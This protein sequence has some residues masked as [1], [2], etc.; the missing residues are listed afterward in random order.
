[1]SAA[2]PAD[3]R[4]ASAQRRRFGCFPHRHKESQ[5]LQ[6]GPETC[7]TARLAIYRNGE[8]RPEVEEVQGTGPGELI[9]RLS[10][11]VTAVIR[12]E[13]GAIPE[14]AVDALISNLMHAGFRNA[15]V[16]VLDGG[17]MLR[18]ADHGPGIADKQR[19]LEPGFSSAG[20]AERAVIDGVGA[21]LALVARI[22]AEAGGRLEIA[23]N[24]GSGTV[25]SLSLPASGPTPTQPA[26]G[27]EA[28]PARTPGPGGRAE[29]SEFGKKV[30]LLL[31]ELGGARL[32]TICAEL[33]VAPTAAE[34][35]LEN[36]RRRGLLDPKGGNQMVLTPAGLAFLDGIFAE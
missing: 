7:L 33:R 27:G 29:L 12:E 1:M 30:L 24:L 22:A 26:R 32:E 4:R 21:G 10:T 8:P 19:A 11:R 5:G 3:A 15:S 14:P 13:D 35:E 16:S 18:V 9:H 25:V 20:E 36:L 2:A 23:D 31:A 28:A 6:V 34:L 17:R